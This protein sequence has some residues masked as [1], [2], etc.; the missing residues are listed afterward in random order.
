MTIQVHEAELAQEL[1]VKRAEAEKAEKARIADAVSA[2]EVHP[3]FP[4]TP[5][6]P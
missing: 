1:A 3:S 6:I 2:A 5:Q 4:L